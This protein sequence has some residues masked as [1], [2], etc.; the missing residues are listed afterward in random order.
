MWQHADG[1]T[2]LWLMDGL[3]G[4]SGTVLLGAGS[5]WSVKLIAD[6]NGDG[7]SDIVCQHT[8]GRREL[9]LMDSLSYS[10]DAVLL[11][12]DTGWRPAP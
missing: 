3:S 8:D 6:F 12:A 1:R 11:G 7:K 5:G 2:A 10:D 4:S 9:W